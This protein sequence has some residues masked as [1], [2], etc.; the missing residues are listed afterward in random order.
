MAGKEKNCKNRARS[1][2]VDTAQSLIRV[3]KQSPRS[4]VADSVARRVANVKTRS[5]LKGKRCACWAGRRCACPT[6]SFRSPRLARWITNS[7][8]SA[9]TVQMIAPNASAKG[10]PRCRGACAKRLS[11]RLQH[12]YTVSLEI[13]SV[14]VWKVQDLEVSLVLGIWDL[15]L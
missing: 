4:S 1:C 15:V 11:Q 8:T 6:K 3:T 14:A 5:K 2:V 13:R 12:R 10:V 7:V 9:D